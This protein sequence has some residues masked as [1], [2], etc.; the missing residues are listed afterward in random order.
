MYIYEL[1]TKKSAGQHI[2]NP[3]SASQDGGR[4]DFSKNPWR[5]SP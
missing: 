5:L 2:A 1:I 3:Q 4:A